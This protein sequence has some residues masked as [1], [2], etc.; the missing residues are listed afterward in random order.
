M[1]NA[2]PT[3]NNDF[4]L[5]RSDPGFIIIRTPIKPI[6]IANV[7]CI[8]I[9][10]PKI[11]TASKAATIGAEWAIAIFSESNRNLIP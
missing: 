7:L 6:S 2:E 9:F 5:N 11:G 8:P 4:K 10:S 3:G 1:N